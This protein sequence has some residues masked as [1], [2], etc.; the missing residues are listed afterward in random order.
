ME[1]GEARRHHRFCS[2]EPGKCKT[3]VCAVNLMYSPKNEYFMACSY[4][5]IAN[6]I[7]CTGFSVIAAVTPRE[8]LY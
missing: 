6:A 8:H 7:C 4:S 5:V 1:R 2:E 3:Y